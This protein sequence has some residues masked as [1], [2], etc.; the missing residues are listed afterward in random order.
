M[1]PGLRRRV[2]MGATMLPVVLAGLW[3]AV[4]VSQPG[5]LGVYGWTFGLVLL[6]A[7]S[8]ASSALLEWVG[9]AY[10]PPHEEF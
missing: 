8:G 7:G 3:L 1:S 10:D 4:A 2:Q 9:S 5:P 6:A